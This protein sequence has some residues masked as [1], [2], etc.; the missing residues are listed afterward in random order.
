MKPNAVIIIIVLVLVASCKSESNTN[1]R[2]DNI[3]TISFYKNYQEKLPF[4]AFV[5]TIEIIPL[6][7]T[8]ENLIGEITRVIFDDDTYYVRST[9]G[10]QNAKLFAFNDTGKYLKKIGKKGNGPG[11]YI[12]FKDFSIDSNHNIIIAD[13]QRILV[14]DKDGTFSHA[15]PLGTYFSAMEIVCTPAD[16]ILA[17]YASP[18]LFDNN[19]L[20]II[21]RDGVVRNFFNRGKVEAIRCGLLNKW[22]SL[23]A[24]DTCYYL[25][26]AYCD[27]IFAI[28]QNLKD[29]SAKYFIDYGKNKLSNI[30]VRPDE[31]VLTWR[32]KLSALSNYLNTVSMGFGDDYL[33]IGTA[34]KIYDGYLTLH[35]FKNKK[36]VT[37]RKLIDDMYLKG[38]VVPITAK[39]IPQNM[40]DNDIIWAVE[41]E[42]LINGFKQYWSNLSAPRREAFKRDYAEWYRICTSLKEDDNP[43][44]MRIKVKD[45]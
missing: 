25:N 13:A 28:S 42:I 30:E 4:S 22:R 33:Y 44:L 8:E 5:D 39:R 9:N 17:L 35:S 21:S 2:N 27:T 3:E 31:D 45:F 10:M 40:D 12:L 15:L 36:T 6:E 24:T 19:M 38:M 11:E 16:D 34:D 26:Y 20:S 41:S 37:A 43:V 1:I 23:I 7:T 14:Y 29:F 32:K 18:D